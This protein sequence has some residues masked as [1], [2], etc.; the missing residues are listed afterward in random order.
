VEGGKVQKC[1]SAKVRRCEGGLCYFATFY[2]HTV[3]LEGLRAHDCSDDGMNVG[4]QHSEL[5]FAFCQCP[6]VKLKISLGIRT[7]D[8]L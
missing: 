4:R 8:A 1:K 7:S 6:H 5:P 2:L 3:L